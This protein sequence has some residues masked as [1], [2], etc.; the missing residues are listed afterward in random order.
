MC[1]KL[2]LHMVKYNSAWSLFHVYLKFVWRWFYEQQK[3]WWYKINHSK[4]DG[5]EQTRTSEFKNKYN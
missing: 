1:L 2:P 3:Y 4:F 5:Q